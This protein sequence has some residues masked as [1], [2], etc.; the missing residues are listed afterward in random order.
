[1]SKLLTRRTKTGFT[2]VEL[3]VVIG[4]I[5][6]LIS[7]LLPSLTQ[8]RRA[9]NQVKCASSLKQIGLAF[10]MYENQ[11]RGFWPVAVHDFRNTK[12]PLPTGVELRWYDRL[13]PFITSVQM[14]TYTDIVKIRENSVLWGCP[15]WRANTAGFALSS[16]DDVRPGYGMTYY[17]S[18]FFERAV[19]AV[20]GDEFQ[21]S[22]AYLTPNNNRG[23][24]PRAQKFVGRRSSEFGV[25]VDS[26]THIVNIPGYSSYSYST[27]L[28][29][30]WQPWP[31]N[32][33]QVYTGAG[34]ATMP[35]FYVDGARHAGPRAGRWAS[36][37]SYDDATRG[38]NML[39]GDGHVAGV[40]VREAWTAFTGKNP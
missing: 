36:A 34:A 33:T 31:G 19:N 30:G 18:D 3:L 26:M 29:N 17:A 4:I 32:T 10:A 28:A 35:A 9:A 8:A 22:Y 39:F 38:M 14:D 5:A 21:E 15:E 37:T 25:V 1:M 12:I 27:I 20:S 2:L 7:I 16:S 23:L 40:S 6:L 13:A 11:Y 24:Y